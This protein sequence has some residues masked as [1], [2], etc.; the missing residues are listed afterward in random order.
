MKETDSKGYFLRYA[1]FENPHVHQYTAVF[2]SSQALKIL[3]LGQPPICLLLFDYLEIFLAD[4]AQRA[5][6]VCREIFESCSRLDS[7][8]R[9]AYC[10]IVLVSADD[11]N[12]LFHT[13]FLFKS[14]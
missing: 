7:A 9:I 3:L 6:P 2:L 5:Y 11:A 10:R 1:R 8:V 12:V 14:L 13:L 4:S